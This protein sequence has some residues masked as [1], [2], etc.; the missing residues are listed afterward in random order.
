M[1]LVSK[2]RQW[3]LP[4]PY[5][6]RMRARPLA[7]P[8]PNAGT[9]YAQSHDETTYA[10]AR[11]SRVF[12]DDEFHHVSAVFHHSVKT[13]EVHADGA[14]E[15]QSTYPQDLG[16]LA[17]GDL[18]FGI[19]SNRTR[20]TCYDGLLD[21]IM[22]FDRALSMC[23]IRRVYEAGSAGVCRGDGDVDGLMAYEDNCPDVANLDQ[24]DIDDDGHGDACDCSP[25]NPN[26]GVVPPEVCAL[27]MEHNGG[28]TKLSW[29]SM[30]TEGGAG[31]RYDVL[32]GY[33]DELPVG[34][35]GSESCLEND[36]DALETED[37]FTPAP[38]TAV[39]YLVRA[40]SQCGDGSWGF[41]DGD[42]ERVSPACS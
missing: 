30:A 32:R 10:T 37:S 11:T 15:A 28:V 6:I 24:A 18:W 3:N 2:Y 7:D 16:V 33:I 8:G 39:W 23:E 27:I 36:L 14:L 29:P 42:F 38:G 31:V 35:G 1:A 9:I 12:D 17:N 21:D 4:Y 41:T 5:E 13:I 20:A 40:G 22:I 19:R 25:L 34:I 26:Y